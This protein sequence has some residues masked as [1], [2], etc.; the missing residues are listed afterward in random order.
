MP[1]VKDTLRP[2]NSGPYTNTHVLTL[3]TWFHGVPGLLRN[4]CAS[5]R[6]EWERHGEQHS[7]GRWFGGQLAQ[8]RRRQW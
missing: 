5:L 2:K 4:V 8:R 1:I 3:Q 6:L 7:G